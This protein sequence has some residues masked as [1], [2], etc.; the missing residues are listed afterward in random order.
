MSVSFGCHCPERDKPAT[1]RRW[2]VVRRRCN[3]SAFNGYKWRPS[4]YS[5]LHCRAC[6]ATGRTKARYVEDIRDGRI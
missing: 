5:L 6:K 4:E 1:K 2:V 3:F